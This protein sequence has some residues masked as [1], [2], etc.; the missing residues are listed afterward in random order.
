MMRARKA[1]GL[2][3]WIVGSGVVIAATVAAA[4]LLLQYL[5]P[6]VTVTEVVEGPVVQAFYSTGTVQPQRE[7]PIRSNTAGIL[8]EVLVDKGSQVKKDQPLA[9][10][11]EPALIYTAD[12]T[13]AELEEKLKRAD[14]TNSPVLQ[15]YDAKISAATSML[16]IAQREEKRLTDIIESDAATRVDLD[17]AIDRVKTIWSELESLKAQRAAKL[18]E[19]QREVEVARAAHNIAKWNLD[20]QTLRSPIDGVVLDRPVSL[21]TRVAVNDQIMRVA[22][23]RPANLVVRAAVDEEDV[24]KVRSAQTVKMTLYAFDDTVFTGK[25]TKIYD[26]ADPQRRT[27]EVD[28]ALEEPDERLSPGMT[29]ELA[30]VMSAKEKAL[31]VPSQA[32]QGGAIYSVNRHD[33]VARADAGIGL[34]GIERVE[35]VS[36][37]KPGD[38]VIIT[39]IGSIQ[40]GRHVRTKYLDPVAAAGLNKPRVTNDSFKG[41]N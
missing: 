27:F 1:H 6:T 28:V 14:G 19:L 5:R 15:E 12:K 24:I 18:L 13:R 22:D 37:L 40:P 8:T 26:Q 17:R 20:Q 39:P 21:G 2:L 32:F 41:F 35:I 38:R 33:V 4:A 30:F 16:Q 7:Y 36:G 34:K 11:T 29:G 10:V 3:R 25:V 9:V 23:V 31:V